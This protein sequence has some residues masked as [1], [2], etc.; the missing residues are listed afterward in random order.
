MCFNFFNQ[1]LKDDTIIIFNIDLII[2]NNKFYFNG[3]EKRHLEGCN[4]PRQ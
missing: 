1:S 2:L 4:R 3:F